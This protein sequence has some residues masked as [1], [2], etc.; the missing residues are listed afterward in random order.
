M[1]KSSARLKSVEKK[2]CQLVKAI[3][4]I[5]TACKQRLKQERRWITKEAKGIQC[6]RKCGGDRA[7]S[8]VQ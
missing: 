2:F 1:T 7:I 8:N 4:I 3:I 5:T 6:A